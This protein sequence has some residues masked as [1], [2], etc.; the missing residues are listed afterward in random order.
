MG[1]PQCTDQKDALQALAKSAQKRVA[2]V[3]RVRRKNVTEM[4]LETIQG[5]SRDPFLLALPDPSALPPQDINALV[6]QMG[7]WPVASS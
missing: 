4:I 6:L 7:I 1:L 2:E 5:F 3:R